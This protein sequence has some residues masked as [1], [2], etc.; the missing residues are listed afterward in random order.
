MIATGN[1]VDFGCAARSTTPGIV[2]AVYFNLLRCRV[3]DRRDRPPGRSG[4]KHRLP[5]TRHGP[6]RTPVP[7]V[8]IKRVAKIFTAATIILCPNFIRRAR[9][10]RPIGRINSTASKHN[11]PVPRCQ[12]PLAADQSGGLTRL[13]TSTILQARGDSP[14]T[15]PGQVI[16]NVVLWI[17]G[18]AEI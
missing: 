14:G 18:C 11:P 9:T 7:T 4:G 16:Q 10:S 1:H 17:V 5:L 12:R 6:S 2:P 13:P 3:G 15:G 8:V